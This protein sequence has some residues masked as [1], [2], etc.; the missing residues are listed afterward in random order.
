MARWRAEVAAEKGLSPALAERLRGSSKEELAADAD[1]LL[2]LIPAQ[3]SGPRNPAP[4][5]SQ[6]VRSGA[7]PA[8]LTRADLMRMTP[9]EIERAR[10]EG[11]LDALLGK[12]TS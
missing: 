7:A 11:R 2:A 12:V 9:E 4:D 10:R 1:A 6:G 5:P 3:S 8:Q